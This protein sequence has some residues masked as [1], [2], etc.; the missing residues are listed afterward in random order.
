MKR[1][2]KLSV[3]KL[4]FLIIV[5]EL[6]FL[7]TYSVIANVENETLKTIL[8]IFSFAVTSMIS[9][10][11]GQKVGEMKE[12]DALIKEDEQNKE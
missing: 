3:T 11:F 6:C 12:I 9:F 10:Y 4:T 8:N 1:I 5:I 2:T 7:V